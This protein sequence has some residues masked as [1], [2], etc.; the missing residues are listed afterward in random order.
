MRNAAIA[1]RNARH[2]MNLL[3][4]PRALRSGRVLGNPAAR[5]QIAAAAAL[6]GW[7]GGANG[8]WRHHNGGYGWVGPLFWP[9][10]YN[11][12]YDCTIWGDCYGFWG[13]GYPDIYA[14][15]FAPYAYDDLAG[16]FP[17]RRYDRRRGRP[18]DISQMCGNDSRAVAGM[19]V[20][21]IADAVQPT[22]A[23]RAALADLGN[24]SMTAAQAIRA[25]C[26]AQAN[27]TAPGRLAAMQQRIE[28]MVTA[29]GTIRPKLEAFYGQLSDEQK[30]R[31]NALAEDQR[32]TAEGSPAQACGAPPVALEWPAGE[33]ETKI[34]PDDAQ[35]TALKKL[36]DASARAADSLKAACQ[37]G[38]ALSPP[39]RL[40]AT[41]RRLDAMLDAVKQVRA[42]LDDFYATLNDEQKAQFEAIG[43]KR[44]A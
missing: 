5:V 40:A 42:A 43:P 3:S 12:I 41:A 18:L 34:R 37:P 6:A 24:T 44:T 29:V 20:D 33:V 23:Q 11:D 28:A 22:E 13:Y 38:E 14:G 7:H 21:Q 36:G 30:A 8:W 15:V 35:R 1:P 4:N 26:P 25:A 39:A 9:F 19:P 16:Y 10:A 32:K 31:F 2:A 27:L 17:Q